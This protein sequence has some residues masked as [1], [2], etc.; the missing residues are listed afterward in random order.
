MSKVLKEC[1]ASVG[2]YV[3]ASGQEKKRYRNI[4]NL[5]DTKIGPSIKLD[6]IPLVKG[7]WDGWIY[8]RDP[9]PKQN[10]PKLD[11]KQDFDDDIGF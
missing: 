3:N 5:I 4:G 1:I 2:S 8:L 7:G 6:F 9:L 11:T 10:E